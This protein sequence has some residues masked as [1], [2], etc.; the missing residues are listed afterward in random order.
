[1]NDQASGLRKLATHAKPA[2]REVRS[3]CEVLA[4][5]SGKG[6][7]GKTNVALNVA[8]A[9]A[10]RQQRVLILDA[11]IG[12]A[13]M[14]VLLGLDPSHTLGDVLRGQSRLMDTILP[15][16][17]RL[18]LLPGASGMVDFIKS[19][20]SL[21]LHVIED[22]TKLEG[23][24]NYL[25]VDTSAGINANS[26]A[27]LKGADRVLLVCTSEP[28]SIVDAYALCKSL[29]QR[30]HQVTIQIIVNNIATPQ[31]AAD[32]FAKLR[33]AVSHFLKKEIHYLSHVVHDA[34]MVESIYVQRPL[35]LHSPS[36]PASRNLQDL[37]RKLSHP[38]SWEGGKGLTQFFNLLRPDKEI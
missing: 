23:R 11:D 7:V 26:I 18:D 31:E 17:D 15:I 1:M 34:K 33:A 16:Q 2:P 22:V 20:P 32:V 14:D 37:A 27:I 28:T 29:F 5:T 6:G 8:L 38:P 30:T 4:V 12:T 19:S 24:Y 36:S 21:P 3:H 13:N 9:L 10:Q 35:L 25:I